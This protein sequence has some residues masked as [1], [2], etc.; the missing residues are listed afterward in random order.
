MSQTTNLFSGDNLGE[1]WASL[2]I[3][4]W[5]NE[6]QSLQVSHITSRKEFSFFHNSSMDWLLG[7]T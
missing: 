3:T 2:L 7:G 6:S 5:P 1:S 4:Q